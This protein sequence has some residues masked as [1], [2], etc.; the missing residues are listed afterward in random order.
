MQ[1]RLTAA[2]AL[3]AALAAAAPAAAAPSRPWRT[4]HA[5]T[6][7]TLPP[8]VGW[9]PI[10]IAPVGE[11]GPPRYLRSTSAKTK[12]KHGPGPLAHAAR[13]ARLI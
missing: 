11:Y 13:K 5:Q 1:T 4:S 12:M 8:P 9:E 6:A 3:T 2:V 10:I 7:R